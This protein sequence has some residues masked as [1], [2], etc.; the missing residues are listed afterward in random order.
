MGRMKVMVSLALVAAIFATACGSDENNDAT[1]TRAA[2]S[3]PLATRPASTAAAAPTSALPSAAESDGNAPGIPP[4]TGEIKTTPSGLRYIDEVVG[5]GAEAKA[6]QTATVHYTGWLTNGN[7]FDSSRDRGEPYA[8][9]IGQ[10]RVI[11]GWDEGVA[12]MKVGG[13]RRLIIPFELAYGASGRPPVIPPSAA[14][15]FDVELMG[16]Q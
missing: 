8:F 16:V 9:T 2:Q 11:K 1:P 15:I 14:L 4:L 6:G 13:K 12:G 3:T 10:G 5:T 7:K